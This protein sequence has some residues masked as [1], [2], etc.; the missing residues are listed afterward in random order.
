MPI[1]CGGGAGSRRG[2]GCDEQRGRAREGRGIMEGVRGGR[3]G[4][5]MPVRGVEQGRG[6]KQ[7]RVRVTEIDF[8]VVG[9]GRGKGREWRNWGRRRGEV[10]AR[11]ALRGRKYI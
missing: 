10:Y 8:S 1:G 11:Q 2:R 9:K 7:R 5:I 3:A 4:A 6:V